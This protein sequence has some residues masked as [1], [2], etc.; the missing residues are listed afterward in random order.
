VAARLKGANGER[1]RRRGTGDLASA[2]RSTV[3]KT[4][5]TYR[6]LASRRNYW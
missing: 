3:A 6:F 2:T 5:G 1:M 4:N